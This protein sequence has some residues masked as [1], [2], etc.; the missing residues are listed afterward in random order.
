MTVETLK[1]ISVIL[2]ILAG[3][4]FAAAIALFFIL[5][6]NKSFM[7]L[8]GI[9]AKRSIQKIKEENQGRETGEHRITTAPV[10]TAKIPT[11]ALAGGA[12]PAVQPQP[13]TQKLPPGNETAVLSQNQVKLPQIFPGALQKGK[14]PAQ[15]PAAPAAPAGNETA[16]LMQNQMKMPTTF[17]GAAQKAPTPA[18]TAPAAPSNET[19]ILSQNQ[20]KIPEEAPAA[21]ETTKLSPAGALPENTAGAAAPNPQEAETAVLSQNQLHLPEPMTGET[22]ALSQE[23]LPKSQQEPP[24]S[25]TV[26]LAGARPKAGSAAAQ[27]APSNTAFTLEEVVEFAESAEV[28]T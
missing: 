2:F 22:A 9:A 26:D 17:P 4:L 28:I 20:V 21:G 27:N 24:L 5:K 23:K 1:L 12:G 8:S 11:N 16:V 25:E 19:A 18:P 15:A 7:D 13:S 3:L 14:A 10:N 6:V